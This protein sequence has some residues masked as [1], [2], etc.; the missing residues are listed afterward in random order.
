MEAHGG[1]IGVTTLAGG[2][3]EFTITFPRSTPSSPAGG[4]NLIAAQSR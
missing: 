1:T 2:G 3:S 4:E